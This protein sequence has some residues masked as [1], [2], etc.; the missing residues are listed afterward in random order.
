MKLQVQV[1][2]DFE[3]SVIV[4]KCYK[5]PM[6]APLADSFFGKIVVLKSATKWEKDFLMDVF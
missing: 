2:T 5:I 3:D 4:L 1:P 6:K